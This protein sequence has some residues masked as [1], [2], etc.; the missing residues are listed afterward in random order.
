MQTLTRRG[1][2]KK[3]VATSIALTAPYVARANTAKVV[4][5]GG[6][7]GGATA[8]RYLA[9][10]ADDRIDVTLIEPSKHYYSCFFSN[11]Y[12]G[13]LREYA[14]LGHTYERL[15]RVPRLNVVHEWALAIDRDKRTV[16]L[17]S[18]AQIPYDRLVLSPG[19]DLLYDA[20][21]GYSVAASSTMPHAWTSGTQLQ[22]LR[23]LV[24]NMKPGGTFV[25]V[26]PPNPS[27]CPPGPY[28]RISM[29]AHVF[30]HRNPKAKIVIIDPKEQYTKQALF[31][32]GWDQYY[33]NMILWLPASISGGLVEIDVDRMTFKTDFEDFKA[34]AATVVPPQK[35]ASIASEA[36]L[37]DDSGWCPIVPGTM[38]STLDERVFIIGDA[39]IAKAMPKSAYAANSQARFAASAIRQSLNGAAHSSASLSNICWSLIAPGDGV[40]V[41]AQYAPGETTIEPTSNFISQLDESS[42]TRERTAAE[43]DVWYTTVTRDMFG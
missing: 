9:K 14:S 41:G 2:S 29:I 34:D 17:S 21:P 12:I 38:Q 18:G 37:T 13:G 8:A 43:A 30:K 42:E 36:S 27:R 4:V 33:P 26:A 20:V 22:Q 25:M 10:D 1:F 32:A 5:V 15:A 19:I 6:G 39:A 3:L 11:L 7:A 28:E 24:E 35:A 16:R 31:E 23:Y 40:R